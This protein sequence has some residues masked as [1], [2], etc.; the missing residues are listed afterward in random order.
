MDML[1][2]AIA[3]IR[4]A[5]TAVMR[6]QTTLQGTSPDGTLNWRY[7]ATFGSGVCVARNRYVLTVAHNLGLDGI[8]NPKEKIFVLAVPNNGTEFSAFP[9]NGVPLD[10]PELDFAVLEIGPAIFGSVELS[11]TPVSF[12]AQDDGSRVLTLGF[13]GVVVSEMRLDS[14]GN[15]MGGAF[16]LRSHANEGIIAANYLDGPNGRPM[17]EFNVGWHHGESGGPVTTCTDN[18]AVITLMQDYRNIQSPHG[19]QAGPRRGRSLAIIEKELRAL[20]VDTV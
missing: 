8:R 13:P 12:Q 16:F 17:Y 10:M 19:V 20:G 9:V 3:T 5:V 6:L 1:K 18:P 15:F 2:G 14:T 4:P 11:S 7:D